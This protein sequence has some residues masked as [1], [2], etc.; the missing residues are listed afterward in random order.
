MVNIGTK[1][2]S[3]SVTNNNSSLINEANNELLSLFSET[4]NYFKQKGE[5]LK[6]ISMGEIINR[7]FNE[8]ETSFLETVCFSCG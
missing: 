7:E 1:Y 6:N 2:N 3:F 4:W 8:Y 5:Y